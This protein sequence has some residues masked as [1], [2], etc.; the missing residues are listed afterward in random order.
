MNQS[1]HI[2]DRKCYESWQQRWQRLTGVLPP[3]IRYV[4][5]KMVVNP[6]VQIVPQ[7]TKAQLQNLN[8]PRKVA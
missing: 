8:R 6:P 4:K 2:I 5:G 1:S 3:Q 7:R